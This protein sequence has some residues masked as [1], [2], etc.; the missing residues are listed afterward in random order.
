MRL[1]VLA[2]A[3]MASSCTAG[4]PARLHRPC[5]RVTA[6]L[7]CAAAPLATAPPLAFRLDDEPED[8]VPDVALTRS[9]DGTT[10]TATFRF[11]SSRVLGIDDVWE[12]G[13]LTGLWLRDEE[14]V[15]HTTDLTLV[16]ERGE[17]KQLVAILVLK[18]REE[19]QR[20][21]RFMKRYAELHE[22]AFEASGEAAGGGSN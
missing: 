9:R 1:C 10:G 5:A 2:A 22:L 16:F 3:A 20:F 13:L 21:I 19:W 4:A 14:G 18:S 11:G 17:P 7:A 12:N 8:A 6:A 15:L